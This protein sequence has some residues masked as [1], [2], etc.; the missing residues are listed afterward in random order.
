M[1]EVDYADKRVRRLCTNEREA[2]KELGAQIAKHLQ[3]R[4]NEIH[5][6]AVVE[7]LLVGQGNWEELTG[8][9]IGQWSAHLGRNWRLIVQAYRGDVLVL[10]VDIVDYH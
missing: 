2:K 6:V 10:V 8:D 9:R 1:A 5:H 4:M 7:D 3:N